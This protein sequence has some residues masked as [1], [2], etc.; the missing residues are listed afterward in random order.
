MSENKT[1]NEDNLSSYENQAIMDILSK[2]TE[3]DRIYQNNSLE[4]NQRI[5]IQFQTVAAQLTCLYNAALANA[6]YPEREALLWNTFSAAA[7]TLTQHHKACQDALKALPEAATERA[8]R[9]RDREACHWAAGRRRT[10]RREDLL[11]HLSGRPPPDQRAKPSHSGSHASHRGSPR[12]SYRRRRAS[13]SPLGHTPSIFN[14]AVQYS[15][16]ASL[17]RPLPSPPRDGGDVVMGSPQHKKPRY[18]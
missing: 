11:G 15:V 9:R 18:M 10:L 3:A 8:W 6:R 13:P 4:Y 12:P 17:K 14:E 1:N 5:H 7:T 16:N 2:E